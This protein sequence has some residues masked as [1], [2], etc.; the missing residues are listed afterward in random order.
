MLRQLDGSPGDKNPVEKAI[1]MPTSFGQLDAVVLSNA[2]GSETVVQRLRKKDGS[3]TYSWLEVP[4]KGN[5]IPNLEGFEVTRSSSG[6]T[7]GVKL[8]VQEKYGSSGALSVIPS[9]SYVTTM[10]QSLEDQNFLMRAESVLIGF[11]AL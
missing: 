8:G 3:D 9:R 1:S 6:D 10:T 11:G 4:K 5:G 7:F 2:D